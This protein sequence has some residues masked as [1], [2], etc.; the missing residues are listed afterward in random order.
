MW[1]RLQ[2]LLYLRSLESSENCSSVSYSIFFNLKLLYVKAL[3]LGKLPQCYRNDRKRFMICKLMKFI[4]TKVISIQSLNI[5]HECLG[6]HTYYLCQEIPLNSRIRQHFWGQWYPL[7][8][9]CSSPKTEQLPMLSFTK[10]H[11][12]LKRSKLKNSQKI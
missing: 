2:S 11:T 3:K 6:P 5:P 12:T 1:S 8:F 9:W 4:S 10:R 7:S